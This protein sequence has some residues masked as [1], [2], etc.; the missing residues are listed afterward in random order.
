VADDETHTDLLAAAKAGSTPQVRTALRLG[1]NPNA[2]DDLGSTAL[3]HAALRDLPAMISALLGGGADLD[4][5]NDVGQTPLLVAA[6]DQNRRHTATVKMLVEQ[7]RNLDLSDLS[8]YAVLHALVF[9]D[10]AVLL[11]KAIDLGADIE[12]LDKTGATPFLFAATYA[13]ARCLQVLVD[14]GA[15]ITARDFEGRGA[16]EL[17]VKWGTLMSSA[18]AIGTSAK[19]LKWAQVDAGGQAD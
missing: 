19:V 7:C 15:D 3:H 10:D 1:A 16:A 14:A 5:Q 13:N 11:R 12:H 8:G 6:M 9:M 4:A 18:M 17:L 2:R